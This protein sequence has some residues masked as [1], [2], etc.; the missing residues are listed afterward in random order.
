M[1]KPVITYFGGMKYLLLL[2]LVSTAASAQTSLT[3]IP[4][5]CTVSNRNNE[6]SSLATYQDRIIL[7]PQYPARYIYAIDTA[8]VDA[9]LAGQTPKDTLYEY[10]FENLY[11]LL[12]KLRG[13]QGME[14]SVVVGDQLFMSVETESYNDN[15]YVVRGRIAGKR[16][17]WTRRILSPSPN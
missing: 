2:L 6:Y 4:L 12:A 9:V 8:Y 13:Y 17:G 11:E 7:M 1:E 10:R 16:Y 15:G 14:G 5:P 3:D